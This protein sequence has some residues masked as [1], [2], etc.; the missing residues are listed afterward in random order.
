MGVS[1][2]GDAFGD[3]GSTSV[4]QR[5]RPNPSL[6]SLCEN[7]RA[8]RSLW[9]RLVFYVDESTGAEKASRDHRERSAALFTQT[10][11]GGDHRMVFFSASGHLHELT[12]NPL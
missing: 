3:K 1:D 7:T 4:L 5:S 6:T 9:S 8:D 11:Q 10:R 12:K 2:D